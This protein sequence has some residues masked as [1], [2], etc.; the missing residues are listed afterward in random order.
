MKKLVLTALC[1]AV[2]AACGGSGSSN[3]DGTVTLTPDANTEEPP[4]ACNPVTQA[5]CA[6]GEKC[7]QLVESEDPFLARTA[8]VP[9]GSVTTGGA[10]T[11]GAPGATT[12]FDDCVA[13]NECLNGVCTTICDTGPPDGCRSEDE[14]FGEGSYCTLFADLFTDNIGLCT[15]GCNPTADTVADGAA[16]NGT[17][18]AGNGCYLNSTRGIAGCAG[19]PAP[20]AELTQNDD[21]YGPSTGGCYLNGCA[22]GFSALLNNV[23]GPDATGSVCTRYCTP[24]PSHIGAQGA[25]EGVNGN[26]TIAT[27][28][29]VGGTNGV[30]GEHQCRFVQTFYSNTD[31][32]PNAV[33]MCVPVNP[34]GGGTWDDCRLFDWVGIQTAWNGKADVDAANA[35]FDQFCLTTPD[36]PMN[37]DVKTECLGFYRG[38]I[39]I[40]E[41]N[42][43]LQDYGAAPMMNRKARAARLH[44]DLPDMLN[45]SALQG[46]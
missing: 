25:I 29:Q 16:T 17:C 43:Q 35:A 22:S 21:C 46:L 32:V 20:A 13:G 14:A 34:A 39:S 6:T 19:V 28:G 3:D 41:E 42:A 12:G 38:C 30:N 27:L 9:D 5:G 31:Q 11:S 15:P 23:P 33:G 40:E 18:G 44:I 1:A 26:C 2:M 7:G 10:C 8:C 24:A 45:T 37:S 36:D 4:A